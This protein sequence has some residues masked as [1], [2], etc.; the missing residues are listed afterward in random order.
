MTWSNRAFLRSPRC[1][2]WNPCAWKRQ[3][4]WYV[5]GDWWGEHTN[6]IAILYAICSMYGIVTHMAAWSFGQMLVNIYKSSIHE[7]YGYAVCL[8][9]EFK[10]S[11]REIDLILYRSRLDKTWIQPP[12]LALFHPTWR[13]Q[14]RKKW[15]TKNDMDLCQGYV[16]I[17]IYYI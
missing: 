10:H 7:A 9:L 1:A 12:S 16:C 13:S 5:L 17:Y 6:V 8:I 14:R 11:F 4:S 15:M 2:A 3:Q